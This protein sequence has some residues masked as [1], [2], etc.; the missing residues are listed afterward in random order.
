[1]IGLWFY[2]LGI[3][4]VVIIQK[5]IF[6]LMLFLKEILRFP[7]YIVRVAVKYAVNILPKQKLGFL[8]I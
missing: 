7:H 3:F 6:V 1:M 2:K 4:L 8:K 5:E